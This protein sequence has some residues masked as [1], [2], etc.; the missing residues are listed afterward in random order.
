MS[1]IAPTSRTTLEIAEPE[2]FCPI[3][4][5]ELAIDKFSVKCHEFATVF[6]TEAQT[7][8]TWRGNR[9]IPTRQCR[10]R[11]ATLKKEWEERGLI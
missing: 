6:G 1:I 10:I 4:L 11:A 8:S 9:R 2:E 5:L 7:I 3:A